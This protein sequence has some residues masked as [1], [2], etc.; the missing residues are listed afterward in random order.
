MTVACE[1]CGSPSADALCVRCGRV[2]CERC[3]NGLGELCVECAPRSKGNAFSTGISSAGLRTLGILFLAVGLMITLMAV[4]Q[5][6]DEGVIVNFPFFFKVGGWAAVAMTLGF[7]GLFLVISIHPRFLAS[8]GGRSGG[9]GQQNWGYGSSEPETTEYLITVDLPKG[10]RKT[11]YIERGEGMIHIRSNFN[12]SF[13]RGYRLP[14]GFEVGE[15]NYEYEGS[16]LLLKLRLKRGI[17]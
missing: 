5:G 16:F 6:E 15:Y 14:E 17:I 13:H 10:L 7:F 11:I 4:M 1:I 9:F 2:V 3:F 8:R 12:H